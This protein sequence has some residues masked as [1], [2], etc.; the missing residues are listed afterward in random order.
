M[1]EQKGVEQMPLECHIGARLVGGE[2]P[3]SRA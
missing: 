2:A 3:V 1:A